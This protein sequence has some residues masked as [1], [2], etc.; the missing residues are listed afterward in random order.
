[1][2]RRQLSVLVGLGALAVLCGAA[3]AHGAVS[4]TFAAPT[5]T[6]GLGSGDSASIKRSGSAIAVNGA[7]CGTATVSNTGKIAVNGSTGAETITIDLTG[8]AFAPGAGSETTPEIEIEVNLSTG[9]VFTPDT[10]VVQG[11][12]AA[13][14]YRLG[15]SGINLNNDDD[16]D[17]TGPSSGAL[18]STSA[19]AVSVLGGGG[20]DTISGSGATAGLSAPVPFTISLDLQG[21]DQND[22]L[23]GGDGKDRLTGG[24]MADLESGASGDDTFDEEAAANGN[25]DLLADYRDTIDYSARTADVSVTLDGLA[26]DGQP[27]VELDNVHDGGWFLFGSGNDTFLDASGAYVSRSVFGGLGADDLTGGTRYDYL[28]G[29]GPPDYAQYRGSACDADTGDTIHGGDSGDEIYG[30][31]GADHL[32]GDGAQDIFHEDAELSA[33]GADDLSGGAGEDGVTYRNRDSATYSIKLDNL[34]NDGAPGEADNVRDDVEDVVGNLLGKNT[35]AG[36]AV[37]NVLTGGNDV[38]MITAGAGADRLDGR[39]G[40]D[41]LDGGPNDDTINGWYGNDKLLGKGENDTLYGDWDNDSLYGGPGTDNEYGYSGSDVFYEDGAAN[42]NDTFH[43]EAGTDTLSY[44]AR[45]APVLVTI[46]DVADDGAVGEQDSALKDVEN[47]LGGAGGDSLTG[48]EFDNT[49]DGGLGPDVLEGGAGADTASY[50][51]RGGRVFVK[52]DDLANDGADA[53]VNHVGEEGDNVKSSV[54]TVAGG[55]GPDELVGS[56]GANTLAGGPGDD[57]LDGGTGADTL[58]GDA[59]IDTATYAGRTTRVA[60]SIDG[61]ANDGTDADVNGIGEESDNVSLTVE[62]LVGGSAYD[63]LVGSAGANILHGG[64]GV[65]TLDGGLGKDVLARDDAFDTASYAGR[66]GRVAVRIDGVANDG[67]DANGDG[68]AEEGDNVLTARVEGG[69]GNDLMVGSTED[70]VLDGGPGDDL[71]DGANGEDRLYGNTGIDTATYAKRTTRVSVTLDGVANDG[72][73]TANSGGGERDNAAVENLV[74]G[75]GDDELVG[76]DSDNVLDGG[77]GTDDLDGK[78]GLDTVDYAS[79]TQAVAVSLDGL[80]NDGLDANGDKISMSVEEGDNVRP[81]I[82]NALTGSGNDYLAG[83]SAANKLDGGAGADSMLGGGGA[84]TILAGSGDDP[85]LDGGIGADLVDGGLGTDTAVYSGRGQSVAVLLDGLPN[86]GTDLTLDGV[87]EENDNVLATENVV[88]GSANDFLAGSSVPNQLDGGAG[89]DTLHG[90]SAGAPGGPTDGDVLVGGAGADNLYGHAGDD[91]LTGGP[92]GDFEYGSDGDDTFH[93]ETAA[94][95]A[96]ALDGGAGI[97]LADYSSRTANLTI[98]LDD[99]S[100]DGAAGENDNVKSSVERVDGGGGADVIEGS[101]AVANDLYGG[102]GNDKIKGWEGDDLLRG[103]AGADELWGGTQNDELL[104]GDGPDKLHG[105]ENDDTLDGGLGNDFV[106]GNGDD[107]VLHGGDGD[108]ELHGGAGYTVICSSCDGDDLLYGDAGDDKLYGGAGLA[109]EFFGGEGN[110]Y[111]K[112]ETVFRVE[113]HADTDPGSDTFDGIFG[114]LGEGCGDVSY[115]TR[116][117]SVN[118]SLDDT[119]NDGELGEGDNL[120]SAVDWVTG[121]SGDDTLSGSDAKDDLNG[122]P[123]ND[124]V[125]GGDG[126]DVLTGWSGDDTVYGG[127]GNDTLAPASTETGVDTLYGE[128]GNDNFYNIQDGSVDKADGGAGTDNVGTKDS[129]DVLVAIP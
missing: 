129:F 96:D 75:S 48:S 95:G 76:D 16:A 80:P 25:D 128:G 42:G 4:C 83:S 21:G 127:D 115:D 8:G 116:T 51:G 22:V 89:T 2:N 71:L 54:E 77:P 99:A 20:Q 82:E 53:D 36:S 103:A 50:A 69:S 70:N 39:Y 31:R 12:S 47:L 85:L 7:A 27:A 33:N 102:S 37:G 90:E 108:D 117:A 92:G 59:G 29:C 106:D 61:L 26:N 1:M 119:A 30:G 41:T 3:P 114:E 58:V 40:D 6:I 15:V 123:G 17:V 45:S 73:P 14:T 124:E 43:G 120:K 24:L 55:S 38:D 5:V 109:D 57:T 32:F 9:S 98:K 63:L 49:L 79:R 97:D 67:A 93:Q 105:D 111:E 68:I 122:G 94:N 86:D 52:V 60:V 35:I 126:D 84:D 88:G 23:T 74:G 65:D 121:G 10:I 18:T 118:A 56:A 110:D 44:A 104:G 19:E 34:G 46:D 64:P 101:G 62:N 28:Y 113:F 91:H 107:D 87:S 11:T 78:A 112:C 81:S 66:S 72:D 125:L 13:D 100:G